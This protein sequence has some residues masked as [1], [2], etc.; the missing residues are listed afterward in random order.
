MLFLQFTKTNY[1]Y[2]LIYNKGL[3]GIVMC[4]LFENLTQDFVD[5]VAYIYLIVEQ[6]FDDVYR[7]LAQVLTGRYKRTF[8][9][10]FAEAPENRLHHNAC[11]DAAGEDDL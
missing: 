4:G 9:L 11:R 7:N 2:I 3:C 1:E 10:R 6:M 5:V 8:L